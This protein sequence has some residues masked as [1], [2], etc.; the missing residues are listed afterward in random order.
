M[1]GTASLASLAAGRAERGDGIE[2]PILGLRR[3]V[4]EQALGDPGRRLIGVEARRLEGR[5]PVLARSTA[6][7]RR[8]AVGSAARPASVVVL[9]S[10]TAGWSIS[11][12]VMS[13][14]QSRR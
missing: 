13:A 6:T 3:Q 14:G 11:N 4:S 7:V 12:T 8:F 9:N 5:W 10:M 1:S 2:Q